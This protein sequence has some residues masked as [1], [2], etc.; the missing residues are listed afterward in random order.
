MMRPFLFLILLLLTLP[1]LAVTDLAYSL[2]TGNDALYRGAGHEFLMYCDRRFEG[3][4]SQPWEAGG[5]GLVRNP[6]RASNG[7]VM[8]SRMHEGI[9]IKPTQRD[10][11]G[12]PLDTVCPIAPGIVAYTNTQPGASNYGRYVVIA[13]KVP[14]GTIYSLYAHLASISCQQGQH[15]KPGDTLGIMG[16]SGVGLNKVR[17]HCHLEIGLMINASYDLFC[18]PA[19]KHGLFNGL[20]LAGFNAAD[21]LLA[22]QGGKPVSISR[23]FSTLKEHYR[24]RVPRVG[25]MDI[26]KRHPFLYKGEWGKCPPAL[27]MAFTAEGVPI[28]IYPADVAVEEPVVI[29]CKPM[30]TLQQ[31]CTANR[32]KNSSRDAALTLSGKN[33]INQYLWLEGQYPATSQ[34]KQK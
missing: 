1:G 27:D 14:E 11:N 3:E 9:D 13:H 19:N 33:Y 28:A 16:H 10:S 30:P 20:N 4:V 21:I 15:V 2:P 31:N 12:E 18:P 5:Y 6:F 7:Q 32:V 8:F 17:S 29:S 26:L 34:P 22:S 24:V 25:T 23:Y